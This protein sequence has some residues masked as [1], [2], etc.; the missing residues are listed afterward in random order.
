MN[1]TRYPMAVSFSDSLQVKTKQVVIYVTMG[2]NAVT[3]TR[4]INTQLEQ[5]KNPPLSGIA[6][7]FARPGGYAGRISGHQ[8]L[9][10]AGFVPK[11]DG[12]DRINTAVAYPENEMHGAAC[13]TIL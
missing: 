2:S 11:K 10:N 4:D 5:C 1:N 8:T 3:I 12:K 9:M 7:E 6:I 13:C